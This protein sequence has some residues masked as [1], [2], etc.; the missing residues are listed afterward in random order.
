MSVS[1]AKRALV[2]ANIEA[3]ELD[4]IIC[5]NVANN[6]V[7]PALSTIIQGEINAEC[8]CIDLNGACTGFLYAS[9]IAESFIA[10]KRAKNILIIC[11]EEPT[12]FCN[13]K[14]RDTSVLFGDG[15]GAVVVTEGDALKSLRLTTTSYKDVLY[16]QRIMETTPFAQNSERTTPLV[17][18]GKEL[19]KIAVSASVDDITKVI[20]EAGIEIG[21]VD[22]FIVHQSNKRMLDSIRQ[23][24]KQPQEKFPHNIEKYGNTSSA[25]VLILMDELYRESKLKKG[26]FVIVSA[27]GAGFTSGACLLRWELD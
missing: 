7:V 3:K 14:E 5:S 1:A 25:S 15:A 12:K 13:W 4:F 6:Y 11:A 9:E 23:N 17:M 21:E 2:S 18:L 20:Q 27:F 8:P 22:H 24:L 16:Y 19:F 10:T 26:D